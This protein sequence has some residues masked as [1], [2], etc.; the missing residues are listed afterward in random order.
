MITKDDIVK[1]CRE[2]P[3][4]Q[5]LTAVVNTRDFTEEE[6]EAIDFVIE[7]H[8]SLSLSMA[9]LKDILV[10]KLEIWLASTKDTG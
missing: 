10:N 6:L 2:Y 1:K 5:P 7:A 3:G 4:L 9:H 8:I